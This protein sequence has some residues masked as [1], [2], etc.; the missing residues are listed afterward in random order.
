LLM[1]AL[2]HGKKRFH[3]ISTDEVFGSLELNGDDKFNENTPYDPRSPYSASKA[4][5]D[6]LVRS[7]FHTYN[8][9][10]T[11]SNCSNNYGPF[12]FPEKIIPLFILK[13]LNDN[14]L[15]IYGDGKSIRDYIFVKDHC[16]GIDLVLHDGK[17][18]ETY[19]MGGESEKNG[20]EIADVVLDA[21]KKPKTLKEF[22]GDRLGHDRRYAI[23]NSKIKRELGWSPKVSFEEGIEKTINWYK[24]NINHW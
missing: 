13:A 10:I 11:I 23:D 19:C 9:P 14:P 2:K 16:E 20:I 21:L 12:Q 17:I 24:N 1:A 15:P 3:H 22:V 8:L 7:Y 6:H 4:S 5:S 18:G